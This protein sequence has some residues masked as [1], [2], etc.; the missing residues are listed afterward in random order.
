MELL[1]PLVTGALITWITQIAKKW[2]INPKLLVIVLIGIA[3]VSYT[4]LNDFLPETMKE[5]IITFAL[6]SFAFAKV[7]Y[8]YGLKYILPKL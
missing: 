6:E 8:T 7:L 1:I 2:E 4:L 5:T 3:S